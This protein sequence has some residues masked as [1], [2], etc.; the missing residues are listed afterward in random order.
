MKSSLST[1]KLLLAATLLLKTGVFYAADVL[2]TANLSSVPPSAPINN[3]PLI[4]PSAPTLN[5][6]A[7]ILIDV[8]S[9]KIIA[10]K[11]SEQ[12]LPPASL[13]KMMTLYV[14]SN[15]LNS[16]QIHLTDNVRISRE[17]WKTGGS[18]MFVKE[19]QQVAIEDLLKGIIVDSGN[20]AC[21]AMA[22]HLGGSE[23]G[24]AEIMNQQAQNLGMKDSHF[25]D[26]TGLP[27]ENLYTTAKDLAILGRALIVNFPQYYHWYKQKWFTYNAIRQPNR[28][29]LLW[30][31]SQVD[32]IK[33]GHTNDAGFCLVSSAKH[34]NMRLLAVVMGS[35]TE[36]ARADDSERLLNY[37]FRFFETHELYKGNKTITEI[38]VF[39][40]ATNKLTIGLH[41]D[42]FVTIPN[43]QYQRLSVNTKVSQNLEA[44]I[45]KGD[46][47]GELVVQFDNNVISTQ[48]L[49]ALQDVPQGGIFTR[50]KDS[51]RLTFR[52]WFG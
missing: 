24:F 43:G 9:G 41:E 45:K 23:Q 39:K 49:Y 17:A 1:C 31:D 10:E 2:P 22:E 20:D 36:T 3:K 28:N 8:N 6:K 37:G 44:P 27:D 11:N 4:T 13:T 30:R 21:V 48:N 50:M 47:V 51:I 52:S 40:G 42:Q 16:E 25:T 32:G 15:A 26:S 33:T 35:P 14:I 12:K 19:G 18:R 38:P 7:Y 5:A 34:D 29:R 46:K